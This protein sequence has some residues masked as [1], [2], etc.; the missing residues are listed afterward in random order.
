MWNEYHTDPRKSY[1]FFLR[2]VYGMHADEAWDYVKR[3]GLPPTIGQIR[4]TI[5]DRKATH[6]NS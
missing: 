5:Y 6:Q 2:R 1:Y 4:E 3:R